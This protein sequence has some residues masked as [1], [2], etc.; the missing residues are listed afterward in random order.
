[1]LNKQYKF[2]KHYQSSILFYY[3]SKNNN[4][5]KQYICYNNNR[6]SQSSVK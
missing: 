1:M 2:Y 5:Y 3:K 6:C 4:I